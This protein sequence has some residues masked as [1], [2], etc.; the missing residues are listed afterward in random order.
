MIRCGTGDCCNPGN[1]LYASARC[2]F[3]L[4]FLLFFF[5]SGFVLR[6]AVEVFVFKCR[7]LHV[8]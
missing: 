7:T 5:C 4:I 6:L 1:L 2:V 3:L 8:C